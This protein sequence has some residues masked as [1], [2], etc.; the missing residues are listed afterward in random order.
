MIELKVTSSNLK[1]PNEIVK[2]LNDLLE[3]NGLRCY[4]RAVTNGNH[5]GYGLI[6]I[7]DGSVGIPDNLDSE[8]VTK[9]TIRIIEI[10]RD[11]GNFNQIE[12]LRLS[13]DED[14]ENFIYNHLT[15]NAFRYEKDNY[16]TI[17]R[18]V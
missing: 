4:A 16:I 9:I 11:C 1:T 2:V 18:I 12:I 3:S 6:R 5:L 17:T 15:D 8:K 10:L 14:T 7:A 13:N